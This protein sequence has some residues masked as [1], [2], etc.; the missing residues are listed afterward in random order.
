[1]EFEGT[2]ANVECKLGSGLDHDIFKANH[3]LFCVMDEGVR[4]CKVGYFE[5][6]K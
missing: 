3:E 6:P 4:M 2:S 5:K 1:M